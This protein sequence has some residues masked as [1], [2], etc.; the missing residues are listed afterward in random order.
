MVKYLHGH[1]FSILVGI[2]LGVELLSHIITTQLF[3]E[4]LNYFLKLL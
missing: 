2:H 3:E 1:Q 4:L